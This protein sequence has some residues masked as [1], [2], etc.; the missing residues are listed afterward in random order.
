MID[1]QKH[2]SCVTCPRRAITEWRDLDAQH[3]EL[4]D[5]HKHDRIMEPG[6]ILFH[7]GDPCDGIYCIKDGLVGERRID[8]E[9]RSFL[10]RLSRPGTTVGYQELLS[11]TVH[12]N[13]AEILQPSHICFIGK[14]V[15]RQLLETAPSVGERFLQRSLSDSQDMENALVEAKTIGVRARFLHVLMTFYEHTG[16]Q[17]PEHGHIIQIP[18]TRRDL[19]ELVGT[20]PETISRTI[21]KI[22]DD[23]LVDFKGQQAIISDLDA[24][25]DEIASD[26]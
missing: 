10:I 4:V 8:A 20:A 1:S 25:F 13:S 24:V 12:R 14:S 3:L 21:R 11:K 9:G 19:A 23:G 2:S 15:V 17:H 18:V 7:Q 16:S 6:Q 26:A 5:R 22:Q